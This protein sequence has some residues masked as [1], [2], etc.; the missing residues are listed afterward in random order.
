MGGV[1]ELVANDDIRRISID[2]LRVGIQVEL[3][4]MQE[5]RMGCRRVVGEDV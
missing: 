1:Q 4:G 3:R 5:A 2:G